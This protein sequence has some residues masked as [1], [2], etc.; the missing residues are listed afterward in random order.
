[1]SA[2]IYPPCWIC[3]NPATTGE[4]GIK[5]SD[6]RDVFGAPTVSNQLYLHDA[7]RPNRRVRSLDARLLKSPRKICGYCN[8]TRTQPHDRAWE[9]LSKALRNRTPAITPGSVVRTNR[10]FPHHTAREMLNVHLYFVKLFGCHIVGGDIPIDITGFADSISVERA[11]PLVYLKFGCGRTFAGKPMTGMSN[12]EL[13]LKL[14]DKLCVFATWSYHIE[15]IGVSVTL[16]L[17]QAKWRSSVGAW[18]PRQ[19]TTR[20]KI[21]D[22]SENADIAQ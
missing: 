6:L 3:G 4:H 19:G 7:E 15:N 9:K 5:R 12:M 20:L 10:I 14:P 13:Q 2:T 18:H 1:M 17:D 8:S 22:F 21:A 11:H 16:A